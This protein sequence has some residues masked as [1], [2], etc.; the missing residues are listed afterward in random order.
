MISMLQ[1]ADITMLRQAEIFTLGRL[2]ILINIPLRLLIIELLI[3]DAWW[4]KI[5]LIINNK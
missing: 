5:V 3:I 2:L 4:Q 1:E